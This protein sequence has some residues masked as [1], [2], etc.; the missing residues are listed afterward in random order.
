[1]KNVI[2]ALLVTTFAL[3]LSSAVR[4]DTCKDI[5]HEVAVLAGNVEFAPTLVQPCEV[6]VKFRKEGYTVNKLVELNDKANAVVAAKFKGTDMEQF[7]ELANS[8]TLNA[9]LKGY[10]YGE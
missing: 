9:A 4:A 3:G 5:A 10:T 7:V 6:G 8:A 1:M 2:T